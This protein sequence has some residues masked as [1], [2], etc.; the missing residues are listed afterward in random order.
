MYA[1]DLITL[2]PST[3]NFFLSSQKSAA[4]SIKEEHLLGNSF[5]CPP[6]SVSAYLL[7]LWAFDFI[8]NSTIYKFSSGIHR[9]DVPMNLRSSSAY[10][11]LVR[12]CKPKLALSNTV[13]RSVSDI[14]TIGWGTETTQVSTKVMHCEITT[15]LCPGLMSR[16]SISHE[17]SHLNNMCDT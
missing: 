13:R 12:A 10:L 7:H 14:S 17:T 16:K 4:V 6:P 11:F 5:L 3:N 8:W 15:H 2:R 9:S 1:S